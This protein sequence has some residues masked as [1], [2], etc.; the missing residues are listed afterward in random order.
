[1]EFSEVCI[2]RRAY[3]AASEPK[4]SI[5][6]AATLDDRLIHV[7]VWIDAREDRECSTATLE[8]ENGGR[9]S[10]AWGFALTAKKHCDLEPDASHPLSAA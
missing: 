8:S 9:I 6:N 1:V 4:G 7:A 10:P 3:N 5:L 2:Q